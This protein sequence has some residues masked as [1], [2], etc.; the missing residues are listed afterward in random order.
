[1]TSQEAVSYVHQMLRGSV[2]ALPQG[3]GKEGE[4]TRKA[5]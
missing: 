5:R 2:G 4:A 3:S 1:M